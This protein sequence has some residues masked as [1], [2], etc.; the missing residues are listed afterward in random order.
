MKHLNN[1]G[2]VLVQGMIMIIVAAIVVVI[3]LAPVTTVIDAAI[4]A[5]NFTAETKAMLYL[6]P[7]VILAALVAGFFGMGMQQRQQ[8][9]GV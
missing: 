6:I 5:G 1:K 2:Q 7:T 9:A 3:M 8:Y 4:G